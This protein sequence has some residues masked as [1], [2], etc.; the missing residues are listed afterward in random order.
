MDFDHLAEAA[1]AD[2]SILVIPV[3]LTDIMFLVTLML[4]HNITRGNNNAI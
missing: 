2:T 1:I 4:L 3:L